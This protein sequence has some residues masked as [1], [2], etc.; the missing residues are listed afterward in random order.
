MMQVYL[1]LRIEILAVTRIVNYVSVLFA[2]TRTLLV[3]ITASTRQLGSRAEQRILP[4]ASRR[5]RVPGL[6]PRVQPLTVW[7]MVPRVWTKARVERVNV[8][9]FVR[10]VGCTRVSVKERTRVTGVVVRASMHLVLS[11]YL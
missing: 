7:R 3:V 6:L 4:R 1:G 8:Y 11:P 10:H 5:A 9:S 2:A